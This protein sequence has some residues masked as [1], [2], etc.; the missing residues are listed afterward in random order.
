[1]TSRFGRIGRMMAVW[2]VASS[3]YA[4]E[5]SPPSAKDSVQF[6]AI[7][8]TGTGDSAQYQVAAQ[9]AKA[10][11][12]FPFTFAIMMGDNMYG[13]ER[14]KDYE[15][16]FETPYKPL[17]DAKVEFYAALGNHDDPNQSCTSRST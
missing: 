11:A 4:Q 10:H 9:V 5:V 1:M 17:L 7:G 13:T 2:L 6:L 12:V 16:K 8:D 14:P 3:A 15:K